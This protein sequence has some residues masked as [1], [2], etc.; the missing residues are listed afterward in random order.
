MEA[1]L[2]A[3]HAVPGGP[4]PGSALPIVLTALDTWHV[5]VPCTELPH[6]GGDSSWLAA[7]HPTVVLRLS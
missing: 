5:K 4:W 1:I 7:Q 6:G 2:R 3:P